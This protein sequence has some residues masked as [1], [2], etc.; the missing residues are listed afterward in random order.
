MLK[1]KIYCLCYP[2]HKCL[3]TTFEVCR[4]YTGR[5]IDIEIYFN[6][7]PGYRHWH[8]KTHFCQAVIK[9]VC[10][11]TIIG[12]ILKYFLD[13]FILCYFMRYD[14]DWNVLST[15]LQLQ[16]LLVARFADQH[17]TNQTWWNMMYI[18]WFRL[19]LNLL[20]D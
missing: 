18:H 3:I 5:H 17:F 19:H 8:Q 16:F 2:L 10:S 13:I 9:Y 11:S 20:K 7:H 15:S 14:L 12:R 1:C 6:L 4:L